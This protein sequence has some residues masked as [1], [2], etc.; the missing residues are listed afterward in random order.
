[1]GNCCPTTLK[2]NQR[3]KPRTKSAKKRNLQKRRTFSKKIILAIYGTTNGCCYYCDKLLGSIENC[4]KRWNIDYFVAVST[5]EESSYIER[6]DMSNLIPV[7]R[8]CNSKKHNRT[9][10]QF[11]NAM[12]YPIRC[13]HLEGGMFC[14]QS[15]M[16]K[17]NDRCVLHPFG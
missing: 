11:C 8:V 15:G 7:C 13:R 16:S 10:Y 14:L 2:K 5:F 9:P 12:N 4:D 6:D 3:K 1:M 17:N